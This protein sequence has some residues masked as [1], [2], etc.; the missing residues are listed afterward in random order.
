MAYQAMRLVLWA[1]G[2]SWSVLGV[3][4]LWFFITSNIEDKWGTALVIS[5]A[6]FLP[7]AWYLVSTWKYLN[8]HTQEVRRMG[9]ALP[10]VIFASL[11]LPLLIMVGATK[12]FFFLPVFWLFCA[13]IYPCLQANP[14]FGTGS[15]VRPPHLL[16][17]WLGATRRVFPPLAVLLLGAILMA[18]SFWIERPW[19]HLL[20]GKEL[21]ITAEYGLGE[22][23]SASRLFMDFLGRL[24]YCG[25]LLIAAS[26]IILLFVYRFST[27]ALQTSRLVA[28]ISAAGAYL[29]ICSMTDYFFSWLYFSVSSELP[30]LKAVFFKLSFVHWIIPL[31]LLVAISQG[32]NSRMRS[33]EPALKI[34]IAFYIP[35]FLF[36]LAMSPFFVSDG[37]FSSPFYPTAFLGLQFLSWGFLALSMHRFVY[38]V[39]SFADPDERD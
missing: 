27:K 31:L 32:R 15:L 18:Y 25:S 35:I 26:A 34:I 24:I 21:W 20:S 10:L 17:E 6:L 4:V 23:S 36:D 39:G 3:Y 2:I 5:T 38:P 16:E 12:S 11:Y 22:Y 14:V 33:V 1:Q 30:A 13:S 9:G 19:P 8:N 28:L 29:A 7:A 37:L